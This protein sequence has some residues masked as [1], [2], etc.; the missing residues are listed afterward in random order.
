MEYTIKKLAEIAGVSVR[1]LRYY[2]EINLL[3]PKRINSSGY[4]IY[5]QNEVDLLQQILFYKSMDM[6]L[7]EIQEIISKPDFDIYKSLIEHHE[8]LISRRNQLDSLILTV[9]KTI[10][11]KK[12]ER[13]MAD[14]E[15]FEGFKKEKLAEN[16]KKYGKEIREKSGD[17]TVE[18]SN[19]KFMNL[20]EDDFKKM[21]EIEADMFKSLEEV[22]KTKDLNSAAAKNVFEK[23]KEWL[24]FSW[25]SYSAQAHM[26]LA[27][28]YIADERF[29]KYYNDRA[30]EGVVNILCDIISL[31]AK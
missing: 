13:D 19:K 14:K 18:A 16:E 28:M 22:A 20:S 2:D 3:K 21:Q 26:G 12:G 29:A 15:R 17:K 25:P 4:R 6:R 7:D 5:G 11:Y 30:G 8:K 9:E 24:S 1:T 31:Y 23:H 10:A 27:Q